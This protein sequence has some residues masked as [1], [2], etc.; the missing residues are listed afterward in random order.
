VVV[1]EAGRTGP[2]QLTQQPNGFGGILG[3]DAV[4]VRVVVEP[5]RPVQCLVSGRKV[6]G[7]YVGMGRSVLSLDPPTGRSG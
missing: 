5:R 2:G 7:E 1:A 4:A 3:A 6:G